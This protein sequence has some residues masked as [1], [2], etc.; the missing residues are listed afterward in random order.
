M[1]K[2]SSFLVDKPYLVQVLQFVTFLLFKNLLI[3]RLTHQFLTCEKERK[4]SEQG[5]S[6]IN[7]SVSCWLN[8]GTAYLW[9]ALAISVI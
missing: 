3:F 8:F 4:M 2:S 9:I 1:F 7:R 5:G 6:R